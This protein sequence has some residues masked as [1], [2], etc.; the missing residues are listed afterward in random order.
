MYMIRIQGIHRCL[1]NSIWC[2]SSMYWYTLQK[3]WLEHSGND[4]VLL[5]MLCTYPFYRSSSTLASLIMI[6]FNSIMYQLLSVYLYKLIM[7]TGS[8]IVS[9]IFYLKVKLNHQIFWLTIVIVVTFLVI[10]LTYLYIKVNRLHLPSTLYV[11]V[12]NSSCVF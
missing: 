2:V 12:F 8:P 5:L 6:N 3:T 11:K 10:I 1:M 4:A 7:I 9:W